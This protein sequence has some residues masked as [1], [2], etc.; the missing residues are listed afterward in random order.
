MF[1]V[2][3]WGSDSTYKVA[4]VSTQFAGCSRK[5]VLILQS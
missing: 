5:Y 4:A 2:S 1:P 3:Q